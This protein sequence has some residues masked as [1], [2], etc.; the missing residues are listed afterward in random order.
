M[1]CKWVELVAHLYIGRWI[2]FISDVTSTKIVVI[3]L[4]CVAE[5]AKSSI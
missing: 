2:V 3:S 5:A 1:S 4:S